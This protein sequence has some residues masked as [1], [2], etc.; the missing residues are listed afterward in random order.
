[1][2]FCKYCGGSLPE[3]ANNCPN[4][5]G[6]VNKNA[7]FTNSSTQQQEQ[8][9]VDFMG[10]DGTSEFDPADLDSPNKWAYILAYLWILFF[11]P[12]AVCPDSKVGRFHA[13]QGLLMLIFSAAISIVAGIV[14]GLGWIPLLG[15][16]F[17]VISGFLG[18]AGALIH[19]AAFI[20]QTV[21]ILNKRA[22]ELPL[23]GK[24]RLIK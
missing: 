20:Y 16:I 4:C 15:N 9:K 1:M 18:S 21:N 22:V 12:L 2:A 7:G 3:G 8:P 10:A 14:G 5:G 19:V 17:R 11:L 24:Y 13:N 23:I 6:E